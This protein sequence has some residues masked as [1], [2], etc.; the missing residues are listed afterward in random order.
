MFYKV[1]MIWLTIIFPIAENLNL[2]SMEILRSIVG[3][4]ASDRQLS[5]LLTAAGG[6]AELA[7]NLYF[8]GALFQ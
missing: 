2:E 5:S 1:F 8:E 7:A 6:S 3:A 4:G